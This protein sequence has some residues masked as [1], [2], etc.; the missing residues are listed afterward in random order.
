MDLG[1]GTGAIALALASERLGWSVTASDVFPEVVALANKNA[2]HNK[3]GNV[4]VVCSAWFEAFENRKFNLIVSNPPYIDSLDPHLSEG[5]LRFEPASALVAED[6]GMADI[7]HIVQASLHYLLQD[8]WLMLEH[9]YQQGEQVRDVFIANGFEQ[10]KT[11]LDFGN[12]E[13]VTMGQRL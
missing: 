4:T 2:V 5:D 6:H 8:G 12:N 13:R 10:V 1:T 7:V 3:L 11:V 9:G